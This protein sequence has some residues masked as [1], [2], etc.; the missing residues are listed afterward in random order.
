MATRHDTGA[1][2][3]TL[4]LDLLLASL[5][6]LPRPVLSRL[7][8][9]MIERLDEMDGDPDTEQTGDEGEPD[10]LTKHEGYGPGCSI[11][12]PDYG[13]EEKGEDAQGGDVCLDTRPIADAEA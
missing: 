8:A 12:D 5:P 10:F 11:S 13:G 6:S 7:T 9:R 2:A 1:S 4:P 3:P